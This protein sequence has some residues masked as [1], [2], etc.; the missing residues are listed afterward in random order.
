MT[1]FG[2]LAGNLVFTPGW[3]FGP[4]AADEGSGVHIDGRSPDWSARSS[5]PKQFPQGAVPADHGGRADDGDSGDK[6]REQLGDGADGEAVAGLEAGVGRGSVEEDDLLSQQGVLGHERGARAERVAERGEHGFC[7]FTKHSERVPCRLLP[8]WLL[9][10]R[11]QTR[12]PPFPGPL[13]VFAAHN[14]W[15]SAH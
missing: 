8:S 13:G 1:E 15:S 14:R 7:D 2:Q 12:S 3:V 9:A 5:P 11:A 10:A 4:H 6:L